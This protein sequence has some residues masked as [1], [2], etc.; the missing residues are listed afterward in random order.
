MGNSTNI[1][2]F[3]NDLSSLTGPICW[4]KTS[5][6]ELQGGGGISS[7]SVYRDCED[8]AVNQCEVVKPVSM[9]QFDF[10]VIMD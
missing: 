7:G 1:I 6:G 8:V 5:L 3:L 10:H 2:I 4:S 9:F